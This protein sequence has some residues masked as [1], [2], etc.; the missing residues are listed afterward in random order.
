MRVAIAGAGKVGQ[1]IARALLGSGHKVLLIERERPHFRPAL[2]PDAD[3]MFADAC[4]L[5]TLEAAGIQTADVVIAATGDD[6]ANLVCA[7]LCKTEFASR[8]V[9]ARVNHPSN[10]WLFTQAWGVDVAVSTPVALVAAVEEAVSSGEVVRLMSLQHGHGNII[11]ITLPE[12]SHLVGKRIAH[13]DLPADAAPIAVARGK[14][15]L[16]PVPD[17]VLRAADEIV[18]LVAPHVE[19]QVRA[20]LR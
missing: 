1:S 9:V 7:M 2:V 19:D 10:E 16:T 3:W 5:A 13:L 6:K 12:T 14:N 17:L 11:E 18:L 8:R 15:L 4:E 20:R